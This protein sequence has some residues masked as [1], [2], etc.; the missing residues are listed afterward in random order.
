MS[1]ANRMI[2]AIVMWAFVII[3]A[4]T[5]SS[6]GLAGVGIAVGISY[7]MLMHKA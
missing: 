3:S 1:E 7:L 2:A 4:F 5:G 6:F